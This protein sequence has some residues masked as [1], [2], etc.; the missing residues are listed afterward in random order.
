MAT[1]SDVEAAAPTGRDDLID[2]F[3]DAAAELLTS[4]PPSAITGR[5]LAAAAGVNYGLLHRHI[6]SKNQALALAMDRI[7]DSF[8]A[9]AFDPDTNLPRPNPLQSN[10]TY[11]RASTYVMLDEA[12]FRDVHT[13]SPVITRYRRGLAA[14]RPELSTHK[15]DVLV[16]VSAA[17]HFG[18]APLYR[19]G[20]APALGLDAADPRIDE[21]L[22]S[23]V[24]GLHEGHGPLG[25]VPKP[26]PLQAPIDNKSK[27]VPERP[28]GAKEQLIEAGAAL[29]SDRAPS[30]ISGRELALAAHVNYGLIHHYF[31]SKDEVLRQSLL[32]HR[33][34]F[35]AATDR[36]GRGADYFDVSHF[37]G[38]VRALTWAAI[39]RGGGEDNGRL[40]IAV[41]V[42]GRHPSLESLLTRVAERYGSLTKDQRIALLASVSAQMAWVLL[43]PS[44]EIELGY[45]VETLA[46]DAAAV[47]HRLIRES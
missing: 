21:L 12:T 39:D 45:P 44:V 41:P 16:V 20:L 38:F 22:V 27:A 36:E 32:W 1:P 46:P 28:V 17:L 18:L 34:N 43:R 19:D 13:Q 40:D 37:P 25:S 33:Q 14:A 35:F 30:A 47:L 3:L 15:V 11:W 31:R 9:D 6:G 2:R 8:L 29:L 24:D 7:I 5:R 4:N 10:E 26:R 42:D 23:W